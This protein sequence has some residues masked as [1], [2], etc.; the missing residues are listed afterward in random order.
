[1]AN[2]NSK[3]ARRRRRRRRR[4]LQAVL[5]VVIAVVLIV[6]VA[7]VGFKTGL[8]DSFNYS[9]K[10][11]DLNSY[12]QCMSNDTATV[13]ENGEMTERRLTV[14]GFVSIFERFF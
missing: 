9:T 7:L 14:T 1:M 4:I 2:N 5:P 13:I 10:K 8:F 12:F 6:I 11:A 3:A